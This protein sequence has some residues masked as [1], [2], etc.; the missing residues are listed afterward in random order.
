MFDDA[1]QAGQE[2]W[3]TIAWCCDCWGGEREGQ[4]NCGNG[5]F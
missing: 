1:D 3:L 2:S 5:T 4:E